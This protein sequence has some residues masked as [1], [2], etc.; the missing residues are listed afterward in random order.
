M[1]VVVVGAGVVGLATAIRLCEAGIDVEVWARDITPNTTSD[2]AAAMWY[3]YRAWPAASVTAWSATTYRELFRLADVPGSGV[4]M[5]MG[6]QLL[7]RPAPDPWWVSAVPGFARA[8]RVPPTYADGFRFATPVADMSTYLPFLM[9][10]LQTLGAAVVRRTV[11]DLADVLGHADVVVNCAG[12]GAGQLA[13]DDSL[14][15]VRGQVV[16]VAQ[17]GVEEWLLDEDDPAGPGYVVPRERDV[18]LGGTAQE[19]RVDL[20]PDP[21]EATAI[22]ERCTALEPR[23]AGARVL[24]H[25]V[26][27]R[28]VRS[29]VRV[30]RE[31]DRSVV[32]N[33][34]HGGAGVTL[35]WGCADDA[36][37]LV[38]A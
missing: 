20:A 23:L 14:I 11:S 32:H 34:G 4:R 18:V 38:M 15:P 33:Y 28:P 22:L 7:R 17:S 2:V 26:G 6:T 8:G 35:A 37:R 3:P 19:G 27:L 13:R 16:R 10:R 31:S 9:A 12:L 25:V 30:D 21:E 1:R 29:S 24:E 36:V 5:R